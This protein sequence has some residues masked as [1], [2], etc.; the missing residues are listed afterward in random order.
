MQGLGRVKWVCTNE[1]GNKNTLKWF[2]NHL[3][4]HITVKAY[5]LVFR[6][7]FCCWQIKGNFLTSTPEKSKTCQ[8]RKF[9]LL[10]RLRNFCLIIKKIYIF[11]RNIFSR[12]EAKREF[13]N[14]ILMLRYEDLNG[15]LIQN[16]FI[17]KIYFNLQ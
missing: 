2:I 8:L 7:A 13:N 9:I 1:G 17:Q 15:S 10:K 12:V 14:T 4:I 3:H 11:L 5:H 6:Q 16:K